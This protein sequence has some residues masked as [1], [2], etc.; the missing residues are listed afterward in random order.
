MRLED[1]NES[2]QQ[3]SRVLQGAAQVYAAIQG[4]GTIR[5]LR[6]RSW[7]RTLPWL[8]RPQ[9]AITFRTA[10]AAN[11]A[12]L[13]FATEGHMAVVRSRTVVVKAPWFLVSAIL[14]SVGVCAQVLELRPAGVPGRGGHRRSPAG[15]R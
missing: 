4:G 14:T 13:H 5:D 10:K 3:L 7:R 1:T 15:E 11:R 12:A 9:L 2:E 8:D 6:R